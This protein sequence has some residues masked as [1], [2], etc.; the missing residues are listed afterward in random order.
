MSLTISVS[1]I[2]SQSTSKVLG[3]HKSWERVE[4]GTI[5]RVLNGFAFD[6]ANFNRD[7][8]MPLIRIRDISRTS[9]ET[10]YSGFY[11]EI[12][13]IQHSDLLVGMDGDFNCERWQGPIGL[14]NQ[15]VCKV[16]AYQEFFNKEF[17]AYVLPGYLKAINDFT[18][19]MTVKHLSS[20]TVEE[21]P[22]PLP[23]L[24]EQTRIVAAIEQQFSRLDSAVASL[25]SA[26]AKTKQLRASLLKAAVEGELTKA[27]RETNPTSETGADLLARIL[28]ERRARWEEEQLAR[29]R[30][31]GKVPLTDEW[32][33]DYKEPQGPD[34]ENL[35][36]LPEEWCWTTVEQL[37]IYLRN[38]LPQRP[39][40]LPPGY[41]ILRINAVRPMSVDLDEVRYL[42]L[43]ESDIR[44]YILNDGDILFTRYN[45]SLDL[46]GVAGM[47][48]NCSKPTLHPGKLIRAKT[49]IGK[50]MA[51]YLELAC[52]VGISRAYLESKARTTAG[53][54]GISGSDIKQMPI[55][56]PPLAE[57]VQIV[58]QLEAQLT[59]LA[60]TEETIEHSLKRAEYERQSIL[61][62]AFAGR[63][64]EQ[65]PEDEPASELLRRIREE[66]EKRE[67]IEQVRRREQK[68]VSAQQ[69]KQRKHNAPL[70]DVLIEAGGQLTP[71]E[72]YQRSTE[73][74]KT[75][76]QSE[77]DEHFYIEL[78]AEVTAL[79]IKEERPQPNKVLLYALEQEDET[80]NEEREEESNLKALPRF[81][82][83]MSGENE[84]SEANTDKQPKNK[85]PKPKEEVKKPTLWDE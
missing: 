84:W 75:L 50:P 49:V 82:S 37:I 52:N 17:L 44:D 63:L 51:S 12:Y 38:G 43:L 1:E 54:K 69:R 71:E 64:V 35:P 29:M 15:R 11:D 22:L 31:K 57:Q 34:V 39:E 18:S 42:D 23:P 47:V 21:I 77:Q 62:E 40:V 16:E 78:G 10:R 19:S 60:K 81:E 68:M 27:W 66:R 55:P 73:Q 41:R 24:A 58:A 80:E 46:L 20:K 83:Y 67:K 33:K 65:D 74:R 4:L 72:L 28:A 26:Q 30:E 53:Q 13:L 45:G 5:T 9:T 61:R 85:T 56:L 14:L 7:K 48:R 3:K 59:E 25:K 70:Y 32:K 79:L 8:G 76:P 2:I 36:D 6:S